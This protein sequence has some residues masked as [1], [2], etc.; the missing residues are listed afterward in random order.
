MGCSMSQ[1]AP[2]WIPEKK[3]ETALFRFLQQTKSFHGG[4]STGDLHRWSIEKPE[5]FWAQLWN[6]LGVIG[7]P[8]ARAYQRT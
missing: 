2:L 3:E 7:E 5:E 6:F 8:G 1:L 4:S